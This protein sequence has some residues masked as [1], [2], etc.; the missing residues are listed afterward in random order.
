MIHL[1]DDLEQLTNDASLNLLPQYLG[2]DQPDSILSKIDNLEN[3][4]LPAKT[5]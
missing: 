4:A 2:G 5:R 1:N 3:R